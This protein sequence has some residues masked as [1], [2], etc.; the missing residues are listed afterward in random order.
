MKKIIIYIFAFMALTY[1]VLAYA[2]TNRRAITAIMPIFDCTIQTGSPVIG[3]D[4]K[5]IMHAESAS[6]AASA[7]EAAYIIKS[8]G[9]EKSLDHGFNVI[10][11]FNR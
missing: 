10:C 9:D 4:I 6:D 8:L 5:V 11:E 3:D 1:S 7:L 2:N